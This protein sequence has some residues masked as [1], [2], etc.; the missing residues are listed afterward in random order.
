MRAM[1][2]RM[3]PAAMFL[4]CQ[5]MC[6]YPHRR[7]HHHRRLELQQVPLSQYI[8]HSFTS[9]VRTLCLTRGVPSQPMQTFWLQRSLP[10]RCGDSACVP[11][12][13]SQKHHQA[14]LTHSCSHSAVYSSCF[15]LGHTLPCVS[16]LEKHQVSWVVYHATRCCSCV[17]QECGVQWLACCRSCCMLFLYCG[18]LCQQF[19]N[20]HAPC[21]S[22]QPLPF[23]K[24]CPSAKP[25]ALHGLVLAFRFPST[26]FRRHARHANKSDFRCAARKQHAPRCPCVNMHA[27]PLRTAAG[28]SK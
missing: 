3:C 27:G 6:M 13:H 24:W 25:A 17:A 19:C 7:H 9:P 16:M 4:S 20:H 28:Q 23:D 2:K 1:A 15:V 5:C 22:C 11:L 14:L 21:M 26:G 12:N 10:A 18:L 8:M